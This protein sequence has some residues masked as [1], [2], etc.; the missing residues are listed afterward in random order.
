MPFRNHLCFSIFEL[1]KGVLMINTYIILCD[2]CVFGCFLWAH[3]TATG[4]T[5]PCITRQRACC[6][7]DMNFGVKLF[8]KKL[9]HSTLYNG[10][11]YSC[12][13]G[14]K[15]IH[16]SKRGPCSRHDKTSWNIT[17]WYLLFPACRMLYAHIVWSY[18]MGNHIN[19]TRIDRQPVFAAIFV[20]ALN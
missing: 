19:E 14:F 12:M 9:F 16:V 1:S 10:C 6:S 15:L 13:L 4:S 18:H 7:T 5:G 20:I 11:D 3:L 8:F 2:I 17:V